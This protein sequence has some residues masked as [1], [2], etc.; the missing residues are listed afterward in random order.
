MYDCDKNTGNIKHCV[1]NRLFKRWP[2]MMKGSEDTIQNTANIL[3]FIEY[4]HNY[5]G[6]I[7]DFW[8][9][10]IMLFWFWHAYDVLVEHSNAMSVILAVHLVTKNW[11]HVFRLK[12]SCIRHVFCSAGKCSC[13]IHYT[14]CFT[15]AFMPVL[16]HTILSRV[17]T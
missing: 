9:F 12:S 6:D 8:L 3:I 7:V 17:H 11:A 1:N 5:C 4:Y 14:T 16:F 10:I 15:F 13:H 2:A